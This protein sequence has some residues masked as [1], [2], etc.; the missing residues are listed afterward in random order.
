M[1]KHIVGAL[2]GLC[3]VMGLSAQ[4]AEKDKPLASVTLTRTDIVSRNTFMK[5]IAS[6]EKQAGRALTAAEKKVL[7]DK[8][9]TA[10]LLTQQAESDKIS[11][12]KDELPTDV[13][14]PMYVNAAAQSGL[15]PKEVQDMARLQLMSTKFLQMKQQELTQADNLD[16]AER[17]FKLGNAD[18]EA[19]YRKAIS[20]FLR[21]LI[22][23]FSFVSIDTLKMSDEQK[24]A[25]RAT[26]D[27]FAAQIRSGG[28]AKF[29]D[30]IKKSKD[31]LT[32]TGGES[33]YVREDTPVAT[34]KDKQFMTAL[35]ALKK[36]EISPVLE[37]SSA[38]LIAQITDRREPALVGI[39]EPMMPGQK[40]TPRMQ[41]RQ[42]LVAQKSLEKLV[43]G[44]QGKVDEQGKVL[45]KGKAE[46]IYF[47][48][49]FN[50]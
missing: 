29:D 44:L 26:M 4:A 25:A 43:E 22:I 32:Y 15:T 16:K 24:K 39:D 7:L 47:K 9:I 5:L 30:L 40:V 46:V 3:L 2:L 8:Q 13:K 38:L 21:P 42:T 49:N 34:A 35:F 45:V 14:D 11:L 1:K 41:I 12:T 48:D 20:N 18:Y 50:W 36:D 23:Q 27:E 33:P 31:S 28:K 17:E 10:I 6:Q 19:M 37:S